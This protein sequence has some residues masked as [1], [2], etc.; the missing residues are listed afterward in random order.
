VSIACISCEES[1][2]MIGLPRF[3]CD[4]SISMG[5]WTGVVEPPS[6][7]DNTP[8]TDVLMLSRK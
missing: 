3:P 1:V 7:D 2:I 6:E 4:G 5:S 8:C